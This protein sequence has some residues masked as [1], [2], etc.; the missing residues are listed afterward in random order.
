MNIKLPFLD[1]V[2]YVSVYAKFLK[3]LCKVKCK[4]C[5][6]NKVFIVE[7]VSSIIKH[8]LPPKLKDYGIPTISSMLGNKNIHNALLDIGSSMNLHL[9]YVYQ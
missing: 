6:K 1:D 7:Q 9:Y 3:D 5:V 8:N 4:K 2:K